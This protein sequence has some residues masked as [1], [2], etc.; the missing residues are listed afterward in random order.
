MVEHNIH[1][2]IHIDPYNE[3]VGGYSNK[4]K[5]GITSISTT[6]PTLRTWARNLLNK[7]R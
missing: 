3:V 1:G 6:K 5:Y 7:F 2:D 4:N